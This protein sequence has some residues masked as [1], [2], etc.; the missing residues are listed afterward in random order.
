MDSVDG[1]RLNA[2]LSNKMHNKFES[3]IQKEEKRCN[4]LLQHHLQKAKQKGEE[5]T[6]NI[7][8][9][10]LIKQFTANLEFMHSH[11][12]LLDTERRLQN[13]QQ[14]LKNAK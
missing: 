8:D 6:D 7:A 12:L 10:Q 4:D 1:S 14:F 5:Y 11:K 2:Y 3:M 13:M 9:D